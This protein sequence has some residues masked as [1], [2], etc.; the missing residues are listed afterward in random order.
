MLAGYAL[1][2]LLVQGLVEVATDFVGLPLWTPA[3]AFV[4]MAIGLPIVVATAVVQGGLP[5]LRIVDYVDPNEL[6]GRTPAEVHVIPEAHPLHGVAFLTWRNAI[7]GGVMAAALLVTSVVAYLA[8]WAFGIGPVGSLAAQGILQPDDAVFVAAFENQTPDVAVGL[9]VQALMEEALA[10]S[11]L[12]D[13]VRGTTDRGTT[14][15][16]DT[17][18]QLALARQVGARVVVD[19]EVRPAETGYR[20]YARIRLPDGRVLGGFGST[21]ATVEDLPSEVAG[22]A[23]RIRQRFGESLRE[24]N[25]D[26]EIHGG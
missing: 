10:R 14:L 18:A 1:L 22:L 19:G 25:E 8:M 2:W 3:M 7:L 17:A 23:L 5:G 20:I 26:E 6:E 4:L 24:I 15:P 13:V 9:R 21:A 12:V 11:T 16:G